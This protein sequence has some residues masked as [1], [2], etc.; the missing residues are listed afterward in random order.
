MHQGEIVLAIFATIATEVLSSRFRSSETAFRQRNM[1]GQ[2]R[3]ATLA[4]PT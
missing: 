3:D 2:G 4:L 1:T